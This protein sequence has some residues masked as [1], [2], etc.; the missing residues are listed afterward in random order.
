MTFLRVF[1]FALLWPGPAAA[2]TATVDGVGITTKVVAEDVGNPVFLTAPKSDSRLFVVDKAGRIL[3]FSDGAAQQEPFLD[4]SDLVST[5]NEQGLLGLAFHPNYAENGRFFVNYTDVEGDT[6]IVEYR[7]SDDPNVALEDSAT[8]L[9]SVEQPFSNHNGGWIA[10]GPDSYLYIGM[11]D[12]GGGGDTQGNG[13]NV[14]ALLGKMLR[15][16]VDGEKPYAI[17]PTNPFAKG[18]GAPEVFLYGLRNPW[19]NAFDGDNLYIADVGQNSFEEINVVTIA[20]AGANLGWNTM[21]GPSCFSPPDGC[22]QT[23]LVLP[24]YEYPH[25]EGCS[26]TGGYVYRGK[27]IPEIAGRY[28]FGDYCIGTLL[29]F[30]YADG[31]ADDIVNL[32][33]QLGGLGTINSFGV[34]DDGELY[35]L[36]GEGTIEKVVRAP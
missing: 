26:I 24:I 11:G 3:I 32:S 19:R 17:P 20:D 10:F 36:F 4:I 1:L 2:L 8:T 9:L 16:D 22:D 28:F 25:P 31:R 14:D 5:G 12:G 15:I 21:E 34:D 18:G 35:L 29:S 30:R 33:T 6:Q 7:V 27:A 13:Q 23:G